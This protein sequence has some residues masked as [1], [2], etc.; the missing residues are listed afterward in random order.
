M[1]RYTLPAAFRMES[2]FINRESPQAYKLWAWYPLDDMGGGVV[3]ERTLRHDGQNLNG[4]A[5]TQGSNWEFAPDGTPALH[6]HPTDDFL[7]G[8]SDPG[9]LLQGDLTVSAWVWM[10]AVPAEGD[11]YAITSYSAVGETEATNAQ[12]GI[13]IQ[14]VGG[15]TSLST[16]HENGAGTNNRVTSAV[17]LGAG[18]WNNVI[19]RRDTTAKTIGYFINGSEEAAQS[20]SNNPTGGSSGTFEIG[21]DLAGTDGYLDGFMRDVRFYD[22]VLPASVCQQM[23]YRES[24]FDLYMDPKRS[25]RAFRTVT[26]VAR[27]RDVEA[28]AAIPVASLPDKLDTTPVPGMVLMSVP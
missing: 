6:F 5:Y 7:D 21:A 15:L 19:M 1:R 26:P 16:F 9:M 23:F 20:Y 3:K 18:V 17:A 12:Y 24:R 28:V 10:D 2:Y 14:T 11:Y 13:Y 22:T 25:G 27:D 8:D 4:F